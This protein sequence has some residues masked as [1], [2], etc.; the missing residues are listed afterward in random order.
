MRT[1]PDAD[2]GGGKVEKDEAGLMSS[3]RLA[4]SQTLLDFGS[5]KKPSEK[6]GGFLHIEME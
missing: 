3:K 5:L 4:P 1:L 6:S 2:R